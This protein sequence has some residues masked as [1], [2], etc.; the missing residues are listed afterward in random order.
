M[1]TSNSALANGIRH[2]IDA[3]ASAYLTIKE[4]VVREGYATDID[5]QEERC[6]SRLGE[7][8]FL[9]EG[10]WVILSSGMRERVIAHRYPDVAKAFRDWTSAK[11]V[12]QNRRECERLALR[13]FNNP[14][15]IAAIG[16]M[17]ARVYEE[18]FCRVIERLQTDGVAYLITFDHI[19]PVT[20]FHLAKNVGLDVVKPDRHLVRMA[21][22][23]GFSAPE[24]LCSAIAEITG[25]KLSVVDIVLWRYATL[26]SRYESAIGEFLRPIN[27]ASHY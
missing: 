3:L 10:A 1:A 2:Q 7:Q 24:D 25:D 26:N 6:L 14:R 5:W 18:G 20:S 22:A 23:A 17:C 9:A 8:E 11:I 13:A 4:H 12:V 27:L 21:T 19:G 15:K 16:S